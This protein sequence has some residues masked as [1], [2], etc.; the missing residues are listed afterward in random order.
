MTTDGIIWNRDQAI[1]DLSLAMSN[2][3]SIFVDFNTEG[4]DLSTIGFYDIVDT[5]QKQ[6][7]YDLSNMTVLVGNIFERHDKIS[8][9]TRFP[10]MYLQW[11]QERCFQPV[12]DKC[13]DHNFKHFASFVSRSNWH[14]LKLAS[15]LF[16]N[17]QHKTLQSYHFDPSSDY[18]K[19]N[20]GIEDMIKSNCSGRLDQVVNLYQNCPLLLDSGLKYPIENP[21]GYG[22]VDYYKHFL[23]E[24]VTETYSM[25]NTFFPTEKIW[26][27]IAMM[28]PFMVQGPQ[29]YINRL[30]KLGF[31]TFSDWWDEGYNEDPYEIQ[32]DAI[33]QNLE[34]LSKMKLDDLHAMYQDM[35]PVLS[36]NRERL[37]DFTLQ[38]LALL[39]AVET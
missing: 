14:R 39:H 22:L 37:R 34:T 4:P 30:K 33:E 31:R 16:A 9:R 11:G 18:H 5:L 15:Y 35:L 29:F 24:L 12:A 26:R 8:I 19:D 25:G 21:N 3:Q 2:R 28:T 13:W 32:T 36:H 10:F 27:P 1:M 6:T 17:H 38:D 7:G 23:I 20:I